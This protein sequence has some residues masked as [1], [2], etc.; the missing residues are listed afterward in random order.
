MDRIRPAA[1]AG[2]FY[3]A[4]AD[5]LGRLND[6]CFKSSPLLQKAPRIGIWSSLRCARLKLWDEE[7][8]RLVPFSFLRDPRTA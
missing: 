7:S 8:K 4:E 6:E 5:E 1:V 3:P 2:S